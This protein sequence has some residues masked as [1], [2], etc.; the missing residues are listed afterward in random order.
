MQYSCTSGHVTAL[1]D[2][3]LKRVG[4]D[5]DDDSG[6]GDDSASSNG[7]SNSGTAVMSELGD[8]SNSAT[9]TAPAISR[10]C[11]A[12]HPAAGR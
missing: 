12:P 7:S 3:E 8:N 1:A 11:N 6:C 2:D 5:R 10:A 9:T 4:A